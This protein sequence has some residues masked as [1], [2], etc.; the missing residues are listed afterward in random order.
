MQRGRAA[1]PCRIAMD[2]LDQAGRRRPRPGCARCST[3]ATPATTAGTAPLPRRWPAAPA[4]RSGSPST[5]AV[6]C[7]STAST[8]SRGQAGVW[9]ARPGSPAPASRP[10]RRRHARCD[11]PSWFIA[12]PRMHRVHPVPVAAPRPTSRSSSRMPRPSEKP[13]P[14]ADGRE[15]PAAAVR[16]EIAALPGELL[17]DRAG[18]RGMTVTP[19]D[20][21]QRATR[22]SAATAHRQVRGHQRRRAR[23]VHGQRGALQPEY[24]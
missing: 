17:V 13:V 1:C 2:H 10:V 8:S 6:P 20:Q 24:V 11:A 15:R 3:S 5:V 16:C 7:A 12:E 9:P 4:P 18:G 21:R 23:R 22:R 19:P 14:S